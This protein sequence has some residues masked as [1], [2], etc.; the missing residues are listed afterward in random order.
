VAQIWADHGLK[1]WKVDTFKV[2]NDPIRASGR[3]WSTS[4]GS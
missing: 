2:S 4:S 1:P 3:S